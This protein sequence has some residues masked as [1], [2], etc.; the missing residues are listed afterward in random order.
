MTAGEAEDRAPRWSPDGAWLYFLSDRAE[1]ARRNCTAC[2]WR[3]RVRGADHRETGDRGLRALP[4]GQGIALLSEDP[5]TA[6]EERRERERDDADVFGERWRYA[7]LRLLDLATREIRTLAGEEFA[8][9]HVAALA[10]APDGARCAVI[11][12]PTPEL[13]NNSQPVEL[14]LVELATGATEP[15]C[16]LPSGGSAL[17]WDRAGRR[18]FYLAGAEPGNVAGWAVF[19][20]D[21]AE[22]APRLPTEGLSACP[23]GLCR[24]RDSDPFVTV[25]EGLDTAIDRLDP[26]SGKLT[27]LSRHRGGLA[28]LTASDDGQMVACIHSPPDEPAEVWAGSPEE[29]LERVTDVQAPL[30]AV[31]WGRQERLAWTA[32]DGLAL[33]GLLILQPGKGREDGPFPLITIVHGGPYGRFADSFQLSW[34]PS[35]QWLATAGYAVFLPNPRGGMGHGI[36]FAA[37]VAGAVGMEDWGDIVAGLDRLIAEG[38]ADPDRL[39]IGGWSQG[40]FMTAWAVGQTDRFGAG[41]MGAGV[42]DWGMMV[43]ESD[44]PHF[45]ARLGGSTGWEGVGPHRHDALSPISFVGRVATPVL[46]LHG[47]RDERVPVSQGRFFARGL[48]ERGAV[49]AGRL[50]ARAARPARAPPPARRPA[51]H[52]RLVRPLAAP[53]GGDGRGRKAKGG[54][55]KAEGRFGDAGKGGFPTRPRCRSPTTDER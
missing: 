26:E 50:P 49:R 43:A 7:R 46:I 37:A 21:L 41:V 54:G 38:V 3:G 35:G 40:G 11:T 51:P 55:L 17:T 33:D 4:G 36:R 44:L 6:E 9:R 45:E 52:A 48:R 14:A 31:S 18:L 25:A 10:R 13:D 15:V 16:T 20:V 1:R 22:P 8:A 12:W 28:S 39:G 47:E 53:G 19:A 27:R 42:S 24:G 2:R 5:P 23:A 30:R 29:P 34:A 32:A